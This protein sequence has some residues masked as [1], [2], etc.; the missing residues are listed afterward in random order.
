MKIGKEQV[1]ISLFVD[2]MIMYLSDLKNSTS[3]L[4][5]QIN[6]LSKMATYIINSNKS[7]ANKKNQLEIP[8]R[9]EGF[10]IQR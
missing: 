7:V 1:N 4:V 2:N 5:Q 9:V 8:P 3:E 10:S 6:N